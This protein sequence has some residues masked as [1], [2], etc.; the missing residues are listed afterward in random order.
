MNYRFQYKSIDSI[1]GIDF[2]IS[3]GGIE[4]EVTKKRIY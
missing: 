2:I 3:L 4:N 1:Q